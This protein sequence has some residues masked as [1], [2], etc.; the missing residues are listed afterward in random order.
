[1]FERVHIRIKEITMKDGRLFK[2]DEECTAEIWGVYYR[3]EKSWNAPT[4][5][6]IPKGNAEIIEEENHGYR[7]DTND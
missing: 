2:P 3:V 5:Y 7:N 6:L 1:M 4:G